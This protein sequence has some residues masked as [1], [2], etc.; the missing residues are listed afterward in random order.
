MA[1]AVVDTNLFHA[2]KTGSLHA[3]QVALN[4]GA[5]VN[6]RDR[7]NNT[8]LI[9][10]CDLGHEAIVEFLLKY[11]K[12]RV[13]ANPKDEA[14]ETALM[15]AC[16][17]GNAHIVQQLLLHLPDIKLD[18]RSMNDETCFD[19]AK[20]EKI[21]ALLNA[22]RS[23]AVPHAAPVQ[24]RKRN[25]SHPRIGSSS[26][27]NSA[28][29][30]TAP[31][32][33]THRRASS[34]TPTR[35]PCCRDAEESPQGG[36]LKGRRPR[37]GKEGDLWFPVE[38]KAN[39]K[40]SHQPPM[41]GWE[42]RLKDHPLL[43]GVEERLWK[44]VLAEVVT[45]DLTEKWA[46]ICGLEGAKQVLYESVI[47]PELAPDFF[48]GLKAPPRGV[49]LFGPPGNGKT[50]LAKALANERRST[51]FNIS[52]SSLVSKWLGEGEKLVRALFS[53]ARAL[54]PT[55]IFLDECDAI[56]TARSASEHEG[57]RRLKNEFLL[58]TDGVAT[59]AAGNV[60]VL[61]VGATNRP[62]DLDEAV[63]RRF[64]KRVYIPLP[65][66]PSRCQIAKQLL[67]GESCDL[68][69]SDW[70]AIVQETEGYS[71]ADLKALFAEMV[72]IPVREVLHTLALG[73]GSHTVQQQLHQNTRPVQLADFRKTLAIMRPSV[74]P[75]QL[76]AL[77]G[78][79]RRF[80]S[81]VSAVA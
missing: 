75:E 19:L 20:G 1:G 78:W 46:D 15:K 5:R 45:V 56:L 36:E 37:G 68:S 29:E 67:K 16:R 59:S 7:A 77:E 51:F 14:G 61:V 50:L 64:S 33:V 80:G 18:S 71:A 81:T 55:V 70:D 44:Q 79:N 60:R 22:A 63:L 9:M 10:A 41:K 30:S 69:S 73:S 58:Q 27:S 74:G 39:D 49:L 62:Q 3:V 47:L 31:P 48:T 25:T 66:A 8:P 6:A 11:D 17:R 28:L 52:A 13:L 12:P 32:S 4:G 54:A 57:S 43:R 53:C 42:A 2:I 65:D 72:M 23:G 38:S 26:S 34:S 24:R 35:S 21:L 76:S 40:E